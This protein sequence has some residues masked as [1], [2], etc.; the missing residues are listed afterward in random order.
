MKTIA[1][2]GECMIELNGEPFA[3][4][5]QTYGGDSL[6]TATY[7]ARVSRNTRVHYVTALGRDPLSRG[8]VAHWQADGID[9][10]HVLTDPERQPGLY[11]IQLDAH[12]ERTFL[13]WRNDSAARYLLQHRDWQRIEAALPQFDAIYL[14]G[15]SLA[16]LPPHDRAR[17]IATLVRCTHSR[18]IFDGNYR[19]KLWQSAEETRAAYQALLPHVDL[20][21]MTF[22]DEQALWG[23][24]SPEAS[25]ARLQAAGVRECVLK[26]GAEGARYAQGDTRVT[27]PAETVA[28]VVDTTSAGDAFNA[29]FLAGWLH[30][31]MPRECCALGNRLAAIVIQ[32]KGA[33]IAKEYCQLL[34]NP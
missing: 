17:L 15:I 22:D 9:T 3:A 20:A 18:L 1:L 21:L 28:Q 10:T 5:R 12:G 29:G 25:I 30:G 6:N 23:D 13:Y 26:L 2:I 7:L 24:A 19:P 34:E 4:M 16:I 11:L 14:S 27:V 31:T 32:H 8:M 33:I